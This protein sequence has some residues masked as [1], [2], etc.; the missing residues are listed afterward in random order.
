MDLIHIS[1]SEVEAYVLVR[2]FEG[3]SRE[4]ALEELKSMDCRLD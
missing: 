1:A 4:Q 3:V 2:E